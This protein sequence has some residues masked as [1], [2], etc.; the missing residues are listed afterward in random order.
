MLVS[1]S[2]QMSYGERAALEGILAQLRPHLAVEVGTAEGGSL[3][4]IAAYSEKVLSFDLVPPAAAVSELDNVTC[5]T[6]DSHV[7]LPQVLADLAAEGQAVDFVL[8]DGDHSAEGVQRDLQDL[9]ASDATRLTVILVHDTMNDTVRAGVERVNLP[10]HPKVVLVELDWIPG[11]LARREPYRL[12]LWGGLGLVVVD[13]DRAFN[14]GQNRVDRSAILLDDRHLGG[15]AFQQLRDQGSVRD[16]RF[17]E[18]VALVRPA[19]DFMRAL[20]EHGEQLDMRGA[21][22]IERCLRGRWQTDAHSETIATLTDELARRDRTIL[23]MQRSLSWRVTAPLRALK[24]SLVRLG[25][26]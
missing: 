4:R 14:A 18:L 11:Y 16:D 7:L 22:E 1:A 8:V 12:Q 9:L 5:H 15:R 21:S 3:S 17:H 26:R 6:G 13:S 24:R 19:R 23:D 2:W 25:A 20:E 10:R